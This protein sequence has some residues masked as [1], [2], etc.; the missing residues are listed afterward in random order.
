[1]RDEYTK[2]QR[3][4]FMREELAACT[5]YHRNVLG[6][7]CAHTLSL[8]LRQGGVVQMAD[9]DPHWHLRGAV[10]QPMVQEPI[11]RVPL[12][13]P[14]NA[15]RLELRHERVERQLAQEARRNARHC[16]ICRVA[17][18]TRATCPQR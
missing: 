12:G 13:R 1:M 18:H 9:I 17:G 11:A 5:G 16:G 4:N 10:V 2:V 15:P 14:G 6:L 7:P 8:R 3:A